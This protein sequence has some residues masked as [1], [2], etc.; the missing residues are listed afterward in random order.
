MLRLVLAVLALSFAAIA[1]AKIEV[2]AHRG[3][4]SIKPENSLPA[5]EYALETGA[6]VLEL[7]LG[8]TKDDVLVVTHDP[9]V[10][11]EICLGPD[12]KPV[13][14]EIPVRSL[15]LAE[16][17]KFDCGGVQHPRFPTQKP[18][19]GTSIPSLDEVFKLVKESKLPLA[20]T[21][22]FNIETKIVPRY[23][24]TVMPDPQTFAKMVVA[25]LKE[26]GMTERA[27]VQSFDHRS[28]AA[29]K[30]L[31]PKIKIAILVEGTYADVTGLI[32][33]SGAEIFSPNMNW[34]DKAIVDEAHKA[35]AQVIPWTA[36]KPEDWEWLMSCGVDGIISDDPAALIAWL[37]NRKT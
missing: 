27:V 9:L 14:T 20:K 15:T 2:Q 23:A 36:N 13:T 25:K 10:S 33:A 12:K 35:G 6:D 16:L 21:V 8:V 28:L 37:A 5:F 26:H 11:K 19:A 31:D 32:K 24:G 4:R 22:R 1:H 34:V 30:K 18:I 7:D 3:G 29:V 17:K